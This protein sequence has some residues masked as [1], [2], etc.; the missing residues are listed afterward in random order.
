MQKYK[1]D[2]KFG[3][4]IKANSNRGKTPQTLKSTKNMTESSVHN[5]LQNSL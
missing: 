5:S 2:Y 1:D 3:F 4:S